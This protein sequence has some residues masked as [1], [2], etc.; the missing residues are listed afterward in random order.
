MAMVC[1]NGVVTLFMKVLLQIKTRCLD[2]VECLGLGRALTMKS[3]AFI[4][5]TLPSD[6]QTHI[7][8]QLNINSS[9]P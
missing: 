3:I 1:I 8:Q 5:Q 7:D 4:I 9:Q 6:L 2:E